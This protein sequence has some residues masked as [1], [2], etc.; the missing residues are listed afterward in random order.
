MIY[1]SLVF[2]QSP[3]LSRQSNAFHTI[4]RINVL[5]FMDSTSTAMSVSNIKS[6]EVVSAIGKVWNHTR[7][8]DKDRYD[9]DH[10]N[11]DFIYFVNDDQKVFEAH[12]QDNEITWK[13]SQDDQHL[14]PKLT[15]SRYDRKPVWKYFYKTKPNFLTIET[16][17]FCA[18]I[19][20][21]IKLDYTNQVDNENTIFENT[22]GIDIQA[23]FDRKVYLYTQI[24]ENQRSYLDYIDD[25]IKKFGAIPGQAGFKTYTSSF[26]DNL[27]GYDF[28]TAKAYFGFRATKSIHLEFG[29]NNHFIGNGHRSLLLS[30]YGPN[31]LNLNVFTKFWKF[32]YQNIFAE[33]SPT[34]TVLFN[35]NKLLPKKYA[36]FHYLSFLPNPNFE[37]GV[38]ESVIFAR[39]DHFE[40]QYLNPIILYRAVEHTLNSPDNVLLGSNIRW[41][42]IKGISLYGQLIL[43][44]FYLKEVRAQSG[45][46][47]NKFGG[48]MGI[49]YYNAFGLD[50][51]DMQLEYNAVRP[52]TYTHRDTLPTSTNEFFSVGSYSSYNQ[53]L[54]HLLG[55]NFKEMIAIIK[56]KPLNKVFLQLKALR[57][58][59]G[60]DNSK[61]NWGNNILLPF[62]SIEREYGNF[63]GQGI[64]VRV[65]MLAL[66][67]TYEWRHNYNIYIHGAL[68]RTEIDGQKDKQHYVGA[69]LR[70]NLSQLTLDY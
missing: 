48:Q 37:V 23:Y 21:I 1:G 20:P 64:P 27:K 5:G 26:F 6:K 19:N 3:N 53:P 30:D 67:C 13:D 55:A 32:N 4:D 18:Y 28:F 58:L 14:S 43:D 24:L 54:A 46:W 47:A 41:N 62:Q 12:T 38:F 17:S 2:A 69:G 34:T 60:G 10:V 51:L 29:H 31:Y 65:Q 25:R 66:D 70:I 42:P 50:H 40:L 11:A 49:K 44:E 7:L 63:I 22:R 52:Y 16:P 61:T 59:Y 56:Y 8:T 45:W 35:S 57:T 33:L 68:R 15:R 36:A 39:Q 9:L